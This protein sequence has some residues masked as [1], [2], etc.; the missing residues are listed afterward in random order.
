MTDYVQSLAYLFPRTTQIKFGLD[1]TRALLDALGNPHQQFPTIHVAGTNGKGSVSTLI[2]AALQ[3][4]GLRVGLYTSPHLISFRERIRVD[5]VP[6][7]ESAVAAWTAKLTPTIEEHQATFFE[8]TTAIAFAHFAARQV[9]IAVI[10][11]GLGGRLDSTNVITPLVSVITHIA[12]D[13]QKYLGDT[14][15]SIAR[16]KAAIA[17]PGVPL[18]IGEPDPVLAEV[19]RQAASRMPRAKS[20]RL[21][22]SGPDPSDSWVRTSV[23]MQQ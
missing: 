15:E 20:C 7:S 10:E 21:T 13:H 3:E 18:I 11:V 16:E 8:A 6:M 22:P 23:A 1:T 4:A 19:I 2:A 9:D 14:L 12:L 17:K 5:D